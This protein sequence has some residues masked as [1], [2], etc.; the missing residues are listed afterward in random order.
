M[1]QTKSTEGWPTNYSCQHTHVCSRI[2][3]L[4]AAPKGQGLADQLLLSVHTCILQNISMKKAIEGFEHSISLV[5]QV[6]RWLHPKTKSWP[7]NCCCG[8]THVYFWVNRLR[9]TTNCCCEHTH[10][11]CRIRPC[12]GFGHSKNFGRPI[13]A[14]STHMCVAE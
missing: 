4:R 10:V 3:Q 9:V 5:D 11:W 2:E 6:L 7:T 8:H 12:Q 1:L 14:V 13:A